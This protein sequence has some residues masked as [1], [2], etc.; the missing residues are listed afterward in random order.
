MRVPKQWSL[1][2][3]ESI[4]SFGAWRQNLQYTLSLDQNFASFLVDGFTWQKKSA[5][6][7]LRGLNDDVDPIPE[8]QPR[9]AAQK[10]TQLELM[11][12]QIANFCPVISRNTIVKN[13]TSISCIWQS[14][15]LHY[16]FQSTGAHFIDLDGERP[17]DLFQRLQSFV[18][19]NLLRSDGSIR[20]YGEFP[21]E[22]EEISPSLENFIVLTW[23]RLIH[24]DL[25]GLVKQRYGTELRSQTLA[26]INPE[27]SQCLDSLLEEIT[28][29]S[30][31]KVLRTAFKSS[32]SVK[33]PKSTV[34]SS[35]IKRP[36]CPLCKQAGRTN[37]HHFLSKCKFLPSE[38]KVYMSKVRTASGAHD[39]DSDSENDEVENQNVEDS[40]HTHNL[41]VVSTS[42]VSTKQ[43]SHFKA[44][45][46]QYLVKIT[47]DTG[48]DSM[49]KASV[50]QH[51]GTVIKKSNQSALHADGITPWL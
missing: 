6:D 49:V 21:A 13:S 50:A 43:S 40:S 16:G 10:V 12:G 25:P 7:P 39:Y 28:S 44:F 20:H 1:T 14:I 32:I 34:Q 31:A 22:D 42:L 37:I 24:K 46:K 26:S 2:K 51:I 15:R 11:L 9:T 36:V 18:E 19:D 5:A 30:E 35:D 29:A 41:R 38:D 47:L 17:E 8:A 45:Y 48:A 3:Q 23:L 33:S 27:I 4:T